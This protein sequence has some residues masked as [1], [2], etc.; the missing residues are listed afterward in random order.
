MRSVRLFGK[1]IP[2]LAIVALVMTTGMASA[3]LVGYLSNTVTADIT[4][5]SPMVVG[6]SLGRDSWATTQCWRPAYNGNPGA[7]VDSF[8]ESDISSIHD[9][10]E[11]DWT[12]SITISDVH[13]GETITLYVRS[14]NLADAE[15]IGFEEAI[16][17]NWDGVTCADFESVKFRTDSIYGDLGYGEEHD[18]IALDECYQIDANRVYFGSTNSEWGAGETDVTK[19]VVTFEEAAFG[20]YTFTYRVVPAK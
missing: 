18:L 13:G 11:S 19:I 1:S 3:V 15:I 4:V 6:V 17:T 5:V 16:V 12:D 20:T 14:K 8:P 7:M 2:L 9:W 10:Y